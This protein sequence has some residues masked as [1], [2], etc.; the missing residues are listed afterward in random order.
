M[1]ARRYSQPAPPLCGIAAD[2]LDERAHAL[3][4][5][6]AAVDELARVLMVLSDGTTRHHD[7][8]A[9][10]CAALSL[11]EGTIYS[12]AALARALIRMRARAGAVFSP[13]E[14]AR[15]GA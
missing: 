14:I 6:A 11:D 15:A 13:Q 10:I 7:A 2:L 1:A 8:V 3:A 4:D 12:Q 5:Y 9:T